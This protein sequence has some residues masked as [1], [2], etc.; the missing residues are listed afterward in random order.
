[1]F[2]HK[3]DILNRNLNGLFQKFKPVV[4]KLC[5][6]AKLGDLTVLLILNF[7]NAILSR[8]T[9]RSIFVPYIEWCLVHQRNPYARL[10]DPLNCPERSEGQE[11]HD[12][13]ST[14]D[15]VLRFSLKLSLWL[16]SLKSKFIQQQE[17]RW[18]ER[19]SCQF[20]GW[21]DPGSPGCCGRTAHTALPRVPP[22]G[23]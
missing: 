12:C 11:T 10:F 4:T 16:P 5:A 7:T 1:M 18:R 23:D 19:A 6:V 3:L 22:T 21:A 15:K 2:L 17:G 9:F 13:D 8:T 20:S 14:A